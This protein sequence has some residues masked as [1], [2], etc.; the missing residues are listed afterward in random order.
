MAFELTERVVFDTAPSGAAA[1][2]TPGVKTNVTCTLAPAAR[3]YGKVSWVWNA[4]QVLLAPDR[5]MA[6]TFSG[7]L[8]VFCRVKTCVD[9][10][11]KPLMSLGPV[12]KASRAASGN[13]TVPLGDMA[14]KPDDTTKV[15]VVDAL[16]PGPE[17]VIV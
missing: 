12:A 16:P 11:S 3:V 4:K 6:V 15:A 5:P 1:P 7:A 17:A 14:R 13:W 9:D 2:M 10:V 8:P